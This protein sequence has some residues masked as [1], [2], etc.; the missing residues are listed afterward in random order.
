MRGMR[1][2]DWSSSIDLW[3]WRGL[4]RKELEALKWGEK[5]ERETRPVRVLTRWKLKTRQ[6]FWNKDQ[7]ERFPKDMI[8]IWRLWKLW[9][10]ILRD[11]IWIKPYARWKHLNSFFIQN[12]M[13]RHEVQHIIKLNSKNFRNSHF[14]TSKLWTT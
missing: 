6:G 4:G 12:T 13:Q 2:N 9:S 8:M 5:R 11:L 1:Y 10:R 7:G 3:L 14:P